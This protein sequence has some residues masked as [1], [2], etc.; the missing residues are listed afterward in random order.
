MNSFK[1]TYPAIAAL[2]ALIGTAVQ[3]VAVQGET[4]L[5]KAEAE[6]TLAPAIL[7]FYPQAALLG[8]ELALIKES[9]G[10]IEGGIE[11]LVTDFAFSSPKAAAIIPQAFAVGEWIVAGVGPIKALK[12]SL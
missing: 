7:T 3:N 4:F 2:L 5:Q 10:D 1:T 12:A 9:P 6:L 11:L 8:P